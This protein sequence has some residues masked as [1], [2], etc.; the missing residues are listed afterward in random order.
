MH[1][2]LITHFKDVTPEGDVIELIIWKVPTP[3]PSA[4]TACGGC[5][6]RSSL[7]KRIVPA[8]GW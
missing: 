6:T 5:A 3:V 1:A 8:L 2:L 7:S 4:A